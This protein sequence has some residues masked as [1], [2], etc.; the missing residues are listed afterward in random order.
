MKVTKEDMVA[1][2]TSLTIRRVISVALD[3]VLKYSGDHH[4]QDKTTQADI[5]AV[6]GKLEITKILNLRPA[7][8]T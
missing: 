7:W 2:I 4:N 6:R 1:I 8:A 5:V 3:L